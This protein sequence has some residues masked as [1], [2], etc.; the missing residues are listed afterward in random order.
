MKLLVLLGLLLGQ[1]G[2]LLGLLRLLLGLQNF[3]LG[4]L[5]LEFVLVLLG[6]LVLLAASAPAGIERP[7]PAGGSV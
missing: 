1:F 5:L 2:L 4:Q 7:R 6:L 3:L